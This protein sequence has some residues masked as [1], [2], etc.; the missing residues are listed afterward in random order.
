MIFARFATVAQWQSG[1]QLGMR[2]AASPVCECL[3]RLISPTQLVV[4]AAT[5][6]VAHN[7]R[8]SENVLAKGSA[9]A[10]ET[11]PRTGC[12]VCRFH[13]GELSNG[14]I[15][16]ALPDGRTMGYAARGCP[17]SP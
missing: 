6:Q 9:P 4:L 1:H 5:A 17:A 11:R 14:H 13:G 3:C 8:M 10:R 2:G 12:Y 16:C 7:R 15:R